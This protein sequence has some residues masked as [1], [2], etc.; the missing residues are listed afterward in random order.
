MREAEVGD[1]EQARRDAIGT[2]KLASNACCT[3]TGYQR[4][5]PRRL[6]RSS[7]L[8]RQKM[9]I[10]VSI[11]LKADDRLTSEAAIA[12]LFEHL[13]CIAQVSRRADARGDCAVG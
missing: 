8:N 13:S 4:S 3:G 12:K 2:L 11:V 1:G 6:P 5:K 7:T 9:Q 10:S